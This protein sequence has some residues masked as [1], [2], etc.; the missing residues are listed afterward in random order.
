[1]RGGVRGKSMRG[2]AGQE[3]GAW[4]VLTHYNGR[5]SILRVIPRL[6]H[7][8]RHFSGPRRTA[9]RNCGA[10]WKRRYAKKKRASSVYKNI[11]YFPFTINVNCRGQMYIFVIF[12]SKWFLRFDD[13][14]C[15]FQEGINK[16]CFSFFHTRICGCVYVCKCM[17][18]ILK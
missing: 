12:L 11:M 13:Y 17:C 15:R 4:V 9:A 8:W 18:C 10:R 3:G 14:S 6:N 16:H 5:E 1:M 2:R 7:M